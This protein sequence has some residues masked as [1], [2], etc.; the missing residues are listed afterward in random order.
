MAHNQHGGKTQIEKERKE[1]VRKYIE[2]IGHPN[3]S[4]RTLARQ[5]V[6]ENPHLWAHTKDP[7]EAVR[8]IIKRF[9]GVA[10]DGYTE[11]QQIFKREEMKPSEYMR[12]YMIQGESTAKPTWY[13][14]K[15]LRKVLVLSDLHIPY[16]HNESIE[17]ALNYGFEQGIDSIYINGD[18]IDQAELSRF[19]KDKEARNIQ[20]ELDLTREFLEGLVSLGVKVFYKAGNHDHRL[21]I[22]LAR[23]APELIALDVLQLPKLLG[24]EELGIDYIHD[25]QLAK[26]GKLSVVHGHE[27]GESVFSPVNPARGLF[28]RAKSSV[29]AGH[30]H[31][32]SAHHENNLNGDATACF[33]TGCLCDLQPNYRPFAGLKW[34]HGAAIV[35]VEENGDFSVDNFRI[36]NGKIR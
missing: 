29:L 5:I 26:F 14:P 1:L 27:F 18:L 35:D 2:A 30:N 8:N 13:L 10:N 16:H 12:Q 7:V 25:R 20:Y 6:N 28:L 31:Q 15:E 22:Y 23:N 34:N 17:A 4:N 9:R 32:T 19:L 3:F 24:L 11:D 33:S 21:S 36:I